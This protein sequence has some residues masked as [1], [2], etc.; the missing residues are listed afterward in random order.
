[1]ARTVEAINDGEVHRYFAKPLDFALFQATMTGLATRIETLR[2][3]GKLHVREAREDAFFR[4]IERV[5]PGT[6]DVTRN[7]RGEIV[8]NTALAEL[9]LVDEAACSER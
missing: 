2:R 3:S 6:L 8:I 4:W 7:E 9:D 1:M 5:Y